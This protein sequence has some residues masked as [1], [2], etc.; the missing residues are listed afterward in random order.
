MSA[1][2]LGGAPKESACEVFGR[3]AGV[4]GLLGGAMGLPPEWTDKGGQAD[5]DAQAM[6]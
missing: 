6:K 2:L 5:A 3:G 1:S 4:A